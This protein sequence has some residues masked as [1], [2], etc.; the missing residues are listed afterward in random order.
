M[1]LLVLQVPGLRAEGPSGVSQ[2]AAPGAP[3]EPARK[4]AADAAPA[5]QASASHGEPKLTRG[6]R[7]AQTSLAEATSLHLHIGQRPERASLRMTFGL[8]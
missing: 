4:R 5:T 2:S 6:Q 8:N 3:P 1:D 7:G